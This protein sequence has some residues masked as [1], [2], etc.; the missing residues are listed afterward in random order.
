[1]VTLI[2]PFK[3]RNI[4]GNNAQKFK[5]LQFCK[6]E[7]VIPEELERYLLLKHEVLFIEVRC[8]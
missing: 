7:C 2:K 5:L 4:L 6:K 3:V 1:V 8:I